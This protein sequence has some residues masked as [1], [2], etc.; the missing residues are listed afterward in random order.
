MKKLPRGMQDFKE[1]IT[2]KFVYVDKTR[3]FWEMLDRGKSYFLS[4]PQRFG[5]TLMISTLYY[6]LKGEKELFKDTYIYDKWDFK[7]YPVVR[8]S[9]TEIDSR[10]PETVEASFKFRLGKLYRDYGLTPRSDNY[11]AMFQD[12]IE[13]LS[14]RGEVVVLIDEYDR[15]MLSH[16]G[17]IETANAIRAVMREF[18]IVIKDTE[19]LLR[20][21]LLTGLTKITKVGIF[22]TLNHL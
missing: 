7:E 14:E 16:L 19:P 9:M 13:T 4:R 22:S 5:K 12:L 11:K 6:L 10:T 20:L 3:Y 8:M 1:I 18:Y 15:P 17:D 2:K 21:A